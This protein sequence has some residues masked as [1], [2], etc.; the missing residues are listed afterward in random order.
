M[1]PTDQVPVSILIVG[2]GVFGRTY[3][4]VDFPL[5]RVAVGHRDNGY[6]DNNLSWIFH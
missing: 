1:A 5:A 4:F 6:H 3:M 2:S